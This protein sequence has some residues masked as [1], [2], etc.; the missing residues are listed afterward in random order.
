CRADQIVFG[1]L[2]VDRES[3]VGETA[4]IGGDRL[5]DTVRAAQRLGQRRIVADHPR[6]DQLVRELEPALVEE[7]VDHP[8]R[9]RLV[10]LVHPPAPFRSTPSPQP[11]RNAD[12]RRRAER[13]GGGEAALPPVPSSLHS[14]SLGAPLTFE[15]EPTPAYQSLQ[16]R[17]TVCCG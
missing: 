5:A 13:P 15:G 8:P 11:G 10:V 16:G 3:E 6:S 4:A 12:R 17:R 2:V 1:A 9:D 14:T 7:L